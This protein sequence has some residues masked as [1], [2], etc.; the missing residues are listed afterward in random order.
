MAARTRRV[1]R[2]WSATRAPWASAPTSCRTCTSMPTACTPTTRRAARCAGS[3]RCK[4]RSGTRRR[5][6]S[7]P[8]PCGLDPVELR[9]RNGMT[10]GCRGADRA[11]RGQPGTGGRIAQAGAAGQARCRQHRMTAGAMTVTC[12][13]PG[14]AA[15]TTHGEGVRA[16]GRLRGRPTR[17]SASPRVT[18]T[19]PP[20]GSGWRLAGGEPTGDRAHG[21]R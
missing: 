2:P 8:L 17:T 14:G 4:P 16:R 15:N 13:L 12:E 19:T 5:W 11:G 18:T 20:P 6:T 21:G 1:P 10:Q 7:W 3:A 9:R